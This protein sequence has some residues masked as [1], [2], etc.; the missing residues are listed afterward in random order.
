MNLLTEPYSTQRQRWPRTG[1]HILA[2]FDADSVVV[3]QAYRPAI[4]HFAAAHQ[5]FGGPFS[6]E[7]MSWIK[8]NFLWMMYRSGWGT[9]EGQE[10]TLAVRIRRPAFDAILAAAIH[11][12]HVPEV[13]GERKAWQ[14][15]GKRSDVRLQWDPD[16]GPSGDK[17]ER[18]AIQ[19][20]LRG[21]AIAAYA[22]EWLVDIQDISSFVAEQRQ[23]WFEG[24]RTALLTPREEVY[25]V[26]DPAVA[27]RLG[28][29]PP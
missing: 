19:L 24:D 16:H 1:R 17:Q 6:L 22:S 9:K 21:A 28:I 27:A 25:P 15:L 5:R 23:V 8:P 10:V 3:Y 4:G 2:Q 29:S 20:G 26:A 11:S 13:Y 7:R 12:T 18:R 14:Q